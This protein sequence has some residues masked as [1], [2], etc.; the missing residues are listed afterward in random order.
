MD[1]SKYLFISFRERLDKEE[2]DFLR[3]SVY[4]DI[5]GI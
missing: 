2:Y 5:F 4:V 3:K 1:K